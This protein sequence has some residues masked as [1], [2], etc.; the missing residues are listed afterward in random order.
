MFIDIQQATRASEQNI[1]GLKAWHP[2]ESKKRLARTVTVM[3]HGEAGAREGEAHFSRVVQGGEA[4]DNVEQITLSVGG[5]AM[6]G[7]ILPPAEDRWPIWR[8]IKEAG[9]VVSSSE[10]HRMIQ[11]GAV[12]VD[13]HRVSD[14]K[15][16]L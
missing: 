5:G 6:P 9:L 11:Q 10:A 12:E 16:P 2:M 1:H 7:A 14:G 3:Y 8:V 4:P 13:G 15:Q